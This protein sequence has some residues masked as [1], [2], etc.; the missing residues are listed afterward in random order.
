MPPQ[1][2]RRVEPR[3]ALVRVVGRWG[4]AVYGIY[5]RMSVESALRVG[6][7]LTSTQVHSLEAGFH[8]EELELLQEEVPLLGGAAVERVEEEEA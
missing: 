5:C 4:S 8:R 6:R 1:S 3:P 7:A 2:R